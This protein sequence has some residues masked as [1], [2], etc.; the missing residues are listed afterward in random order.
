MTTIRA[1]I[2][3]RS[4]IVPAPH[5][6]PDGTEVLLTI[7]TNIH[8]DEGPMSSEEIARVHAAMQTLLPLDIPDDVAADLDDWERKIDRY[9]IDNLD[10]GIEDVFR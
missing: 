7:G 3:D 1:R 10:K 6:L 4:I 8:D 2:H 9:G 5:D